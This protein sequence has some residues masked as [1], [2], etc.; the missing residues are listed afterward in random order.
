MEKS[1]QSRV[2]RSYIKEETHKVRTIHRKVNE[3]LNPA[4]RKL[5]EA[6]NGQSL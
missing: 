6:T 2:G 4:L 1:P 5:D 3:I